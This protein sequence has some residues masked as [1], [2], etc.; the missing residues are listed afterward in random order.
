MDGLAER[1]TALG[2]EGLFLRLTPAAPR[3]WRESGAASALAMLAA[4]PSAGA[5]ARFLAAEVI[6]AEGG[7]QPHPALAPTYA[8]VLRETKVADMW[9]LPGE[10]DTPPTRNLLAMGEPAVAALRPL[11]GDERALVFSGGEEATVGNDADWRV[12]DVAA[13]LIAAIRGT[14]F[15]ASA[16]PAAR[17]AARAAM[18][19]GPYGP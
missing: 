10:L 9:G 18:A 2:Y 7:Q 14:V 8:T 19:A 11:L 3:L 6:A 13:S 16:P 4:D 5:H 12:G 17:A 1:L 15:D